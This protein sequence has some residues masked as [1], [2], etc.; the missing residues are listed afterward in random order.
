MRL[1]FRLWALWR[2]VMNLK[3]LVDNLDELIEILKDI[4]NSF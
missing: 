3:R 4:F 1:L 2:L